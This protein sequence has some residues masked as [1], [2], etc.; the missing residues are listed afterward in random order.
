MFCY[1]CGERL[2]DGRTSCQKCGADVPRSILEAEAPPVPK[3]PLSAAAIGLVAA[4]AVGFAGGRLVFRPLHPRPPA[5][6]AAPATGELD[7][8]TPM[9]VRDPS[10]LV[11]GPSDDLYCP[12]PAKKTK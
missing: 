4:L 5:P 8:I 11:M 10:A 3:W 1:K 9:N 12:C 7:L 6:A 2:W